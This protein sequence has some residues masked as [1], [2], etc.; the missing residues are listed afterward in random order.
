MVNVINE[1]VAQLRA[2][3][4]L[5]LVTIWNNQFAY[6]EDGEIYS[7]PMPCAFVE[8]SADSFEQLGNRYQATD[9]IVKIHIGQDFYNGTNIDE[10]LTIF[11]LRDLIVRKLSLFKPTTAGAMVKTSEKQDFEHSNVYH[12]EIDFKTHYIDNTNVNADI[13]TTPPTALQI[14]T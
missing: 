1:I 12:Y 11:V 10:N 14:N 3:P 13:L 9:I 7:F 6:M 4:E 5:K 2:I 8:V